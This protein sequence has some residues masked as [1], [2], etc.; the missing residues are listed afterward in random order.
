MSRAYSFELTLPG[1]AIVPAAAVSWVGV[2]PTHRRR[3]V[4][5][6]MM[7][8][9]HD[10]ARARER[11]RRDPHRVRERH[12]WAVRLRR[13]DVATRP[14]VERTR[15]TFARPF[16]D[17]G[18]VRIVT[19]DEAEKVLPGVY[20]EVRRVRAGMVTRPDYWWPQVFWF[21][22]KRAD[23][24]YFVVVARRRVGQRR[25]VRRRTRSRASGA[26]GVTPNG[27]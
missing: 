27:E 22:R 18:R 25:R 2:L 6:Q 13:R 11:A 15:A 16:D 21:D 12:L 20:D 7:Q 24:A 8:A 23:K 14:P 9:L 17:A 19:R 4:L 1:G 5:T 26:A 3:G 10:D